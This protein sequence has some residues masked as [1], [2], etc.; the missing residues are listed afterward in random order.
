MSMSSLLSDRSFTG[1]SSGVLTSLNVDGFVYV[2]GVDDTVEAVRRTSVDAGFTGCVLMLDI[3][4]I[5][6]SFNQTNTITGSNVVNCDADLCQ[7]APC[8]NGATCAPS[9]GSYSCQCAS[10]YHGDL[11]DIKRDTCN[12]DDLCAEGSL[13]VSMTDGYYCRC[14]LGQSGALCD[15]TQDISGLIPSFSGASYTTYPLTG[16]VSQQTTISLLMRPSSEN[17]LIVI[18]LDESGQGGDFL[19]LVIIEGVV[20]LRFDLGSGVSVVSGGPIELHSWHSI[21]V[22][23]SGSSADLT[24]DGVT[25]TFE[26]SGLVGLSTSSFIYVGGVPAGLDV[27]DDVGIFQG[28]SGCIQNF[29]A[30]GGLDITSCNH[31]LCS[32]M[33]CL[34]EGICQ[35]LNDTT[36]RCQCVAGWSGDQCDQASAVEVPS[37]G[38]GSYLVF[39]DILPSAGTSVI[40]IEFKTSS[41]D[42][43]LFWNS[44]GS[45]FIGVGLSGGRV[46]FTF[47]LGS[48]PA[49][50]FSNSRI[51]LEEWHKVLATRTGQS[52][53]LAIDDELIP[54]SGQVQ[55]ASVGLGVG[56]RTYV[57]GVPAEVVVPGR[58][59]LSGGF[60]GCIRK[61]EVNSQAVLLSEPSQGSGVIE[62]VDQLCN[63]NPDCRNGATCL[64][65]P[66][67]DLM[68]RCLC[69]E[70]YTGSL[71]ETSA[72]DALAEEDRCKNGGT[73]YVGDAGQPLCLCPLG[74]G[75]D[76]CSS[77]MDYSIPQ[78][79][80]R[81]YLEFSRAIIASDFI[82]IGIKDRNVEL[83]VNLGDGILSLV[84]QNIFINFNQLYSVSFDRVG[85]SATMIVQDS[86]GRTDT[87]SGTTPGLQT[88]LNT[89]GSS[90]FIGG[91]PEDISELTGGLYQQSLEGCVIQLATARNPTRNLVTVNLQQE[92]LSGADIDNCT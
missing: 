39:E 90:L 30:V 9:P 66:S 12:G 16:S 36:F 4:G 26:G 69:P 18:L 41:E 72:C 84:A 21:S 8:Q 43:I 62:C 85:T 40:L 76:L 82:A 42:G 74:F 45:D 80:E 22:Y 91:H 11:C 57:G 10:G 13:C 5:T 68:Y 32:E 73:C 81:S 65:D 20:Q 15:Q 23:R 58:A 61:L 88:G 25:T 19:A 60:S 92:P 87:V 6:I 71:C 50:V 78:F 14:A 48:G 49:Y 1:Q 67:S 70:G 29:Q 31:T 2:G 89:F 17:G 44:D 75:G 28:F 3:Q 56:S 34:N 79:S 38:M 27:P 83:R 64:D 53:Q 59:S 54:S 47:D 24:M 7:A 52:G 63:L 35:T 86:I 55:G 33:P 51:T 37:F 77:T 46:V